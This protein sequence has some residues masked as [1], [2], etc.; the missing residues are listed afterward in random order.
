M[1]IGFRGFTSTILFHSSFEMTETINFKA[2]EAIFVANRE[3]LKAKKLLK[4]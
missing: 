2:P 3:E 1:T 4:S